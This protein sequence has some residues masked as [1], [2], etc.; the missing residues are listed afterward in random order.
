MVECGAITIVV[1]GLNSVGIV[2]SS[3][4]VVTGFHTIVGCVWFV[5]LGDEIF[6]V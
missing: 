2:V 5:L 1:K 4:H 3:F 6:V